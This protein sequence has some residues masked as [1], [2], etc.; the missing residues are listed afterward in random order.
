[1]EIETDS[2]VFSKLRVAN[3]DLYLLC[4]GV[5]CNVPRTLINQAF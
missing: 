3:D 1:M 5:A 2:Q 4:R